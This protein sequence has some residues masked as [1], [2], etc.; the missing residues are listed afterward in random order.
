MG[1]SWGE[2]NLPFILSSK[3]FFLKPFKGKLRK[4]PPYY[5]KGLGNRIGGFPPKNPGN[6]GGLIYWRGFFLGFLG[7]IPF[8][9]GFPYSF[10]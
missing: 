3:S 8:H 4:E 2:L 7:L 6:F 1:K 10:G 5:L 9:S